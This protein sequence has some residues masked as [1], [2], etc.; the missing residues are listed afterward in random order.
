MPP[1]PPTSQN[2]IHLHLKNLNFNIFYNDIVNVNKL[3]KR[4]ELINTFL[5]LNIT[6]DLSKFQ[7][8]PLL[9]FSKIF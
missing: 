8:P 9:F 3:I 7:T 2:I 4:N 5:N 1:Y 6:F